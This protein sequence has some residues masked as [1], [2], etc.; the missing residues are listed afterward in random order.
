MYIYNHRYTQLKSIPYRFAY[1]LVPNNN[2][3]NIYRSVQYGQAIRTVKV[4]VTPFSS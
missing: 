3:N 1:A 4:R 2:N